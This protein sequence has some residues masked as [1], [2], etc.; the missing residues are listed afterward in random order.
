MA[1][2]REELQAL[3]LD[4]PLVGDIADADLAEIR[5]AGDGA[6]GGELRAVETDPVIVVRMLVLKGFQYL[7]RI[8]LAVDGWS[9]Q[10]FE[11]FGIPCHIIP[12]L[13]LL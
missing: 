12:P 6:Q 9:A 8:F 11:F 5:L 7:G 2:K 3:G 1:R 10:R 4:H 13:R